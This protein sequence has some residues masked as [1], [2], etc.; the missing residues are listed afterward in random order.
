MLAREC[1]RCG[2]DLSGDIDSWGD[3]SPVFGTCSECGLAFAWGEVLHRERS[4]PRWAV[5]HPQG[6]SLMRGAQTFVRSFWPW[7]FWGAIRMAQPIRP[8]RLALFCLLTYGVMH[9]LIGLTAGVVRYVQLAGFNRQGVDISSALRSLAFLAWPYADPGGGLDL[10]SDGVL[11]AA[12]LIGGAIALPAGFLAL[13]TTLAR[14]RVRRVHLLRGLVL[15]LP[16]PA[17]GFAVAMS[18]VNGS[19]AGWP[20]MDPSMRLLAVACAMISHAAAWWVI[21]SQYLRLEQPALVIV[22]MTTIAWLSWLAVAVWA[23]HWFWCVL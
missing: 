4:V 3:T 5:E 20:G 11:L 16:I 15:T 10:L 13:G 1:P 21:G 7:R 23:E 12:P 22:A 8:R 14:A 18:M 19:A 6:F 9:L 2:Y 17:M